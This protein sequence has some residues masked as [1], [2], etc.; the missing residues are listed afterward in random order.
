MHILRPE[1][2]ISNVGYRETFET[3]PDALLVV[4]KVAGRDWW[5]MTGLESAYFWLLWSPNSDLN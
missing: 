2:W 5:M 4:P 1:L 3:Y